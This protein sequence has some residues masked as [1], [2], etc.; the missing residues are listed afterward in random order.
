MLAGEA[1]GEGEE[2]EIRTERASVA[3]IAV[4]TAIFAVLFLF[5]LLLLLYHN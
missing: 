5:A 2:E 3:Q 4:L 1:K